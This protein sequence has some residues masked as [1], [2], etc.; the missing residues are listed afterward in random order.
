LRVYPYVKDLK[1]C[2]Q[3]M[4]KLP[5]YEGSLVRLQ[6]IKLAVDGYALMYKI[7]EQHRGLIIPMHPQPQFEEIIATIHKADFQVDVHAVGDKGVDWTLQAFAKASGSPRVC[8]DRRHRIEH[9]PFLKKDSLERT[10]EY[11]I[12]VCVQ[13]DIMRVKADDFREKFGPASADLVE[14]MV[15][16]KSFTKTGVHVAYGADVPAF[17]SYLPLDSI[18]AAMERKTTEGRQLDLS[19]SITFLEALQHHTLGSAYAAFDENELGSLEP[20]KKADFVIWN[21]DLKN[22]HKAE[23]IQNLKVQATYLEGKAV[24]RA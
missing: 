5:R 16:L 1:N 11:G 2:L 12:P 20:G 6:G 15:P 21:Q 7:L 4:D 10:A 3:V 13:P 18:R 19:E 8:Q 14:T 23:D 17:P 22:I 9:Y 24:Y